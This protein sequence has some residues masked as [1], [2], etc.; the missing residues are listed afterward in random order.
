MKCDWLEIERFSKSKKSPIG[1][2]VRI[3]D[4]SSINCVCVCTLS[5]SY[6]CYHIEDAVN[7]R[8]LHVRGGRH[9]ETLFEI[10]HVSFIGT[11][12]ELP[13]TDFSTIEMKLDH[14]K[15]N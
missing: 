13:A 8:A 5:Q 9:R 11:L 2:E 6:T 1:Y 4:A 3:L 10:Q 14:R 12:T 15:G 7:A